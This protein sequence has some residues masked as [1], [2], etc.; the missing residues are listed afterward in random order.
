MNQKKIEILNELLAA[1]DEQNFDLNAWKV[2]AT[3][4]VKKIFGE[5]DPKAALIDGLHY[6]YSSWA[7]RDHSGGKIHDSVKD[8]AKEIV[9]AAMVELKL[10][11]GENALMQNIRDELT[12]SEFAFLQEHIASLPESADNLTSFLKELPEG[13][14]EKILSK[15]IVELNKQA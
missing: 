3:L 2:K 5:N 14:T 4:I 8:K 10:E 15:I 1:I 6:D 12:G 13:K 11:E 7:L 9:E